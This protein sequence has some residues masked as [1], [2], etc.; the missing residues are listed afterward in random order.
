MKAC[1]RP[2][3]IRT[4]STLTRAGA[5]DIL[6]S[7]SGGSI[8]LLVQYYTREGAA[9]GRLEPDIMGMPH[10]EGAPALPAPLTGAPADVPRYGAYPLPSGPTI[11]VLFWLVRVALQRTSGCCHIAMPE[12]CMALNQR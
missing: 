10:E 1:C 12:L 6:H 9:S 3:A 2:E 7:A 4:S 8:D 11:Q 5:S